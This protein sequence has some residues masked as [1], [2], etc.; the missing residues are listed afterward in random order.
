MRLL[1]LVSVMD[2]IYITFKCYF[3][4]LSWRK[5]FVVYSLQNKLL[6]LSVYVPE[7]KACFVFISYQLFYPDASD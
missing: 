5:M 1:T 7:D 6:L 4:S 2:F 3:R